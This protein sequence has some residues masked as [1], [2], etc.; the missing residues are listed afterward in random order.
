M[1]P[2]VGG[3]NTES[4]E[5]LGVF[6][7]AFGEGAICKANAAVSDGVVG[8]NDSFPGQAIGRFFT[9][10]KVEKLLA[11]HLLLPQGSEGSTGRTDIDTG[12]TGTTPRLRDGFIG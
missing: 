12:V 5:F 7:P 2:H 9:C 3:R 1:P 4:L 8:F 11:F 10:G 6:D